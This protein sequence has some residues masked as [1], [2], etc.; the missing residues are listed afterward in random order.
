MRLDIAATSENETWVLT[1]E[2]AQALM[3]GWFAA[4]SEELTDELRGVF[5]KALEKLVGVSYEPELYLGS[6]VVAGRNHCFLCR[7]AV[8]YPGALS[9]YTLVYIYE[10]LQGGASILN[11]SKADLGEK[12]PAE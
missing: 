3:G 9:Y 1:D 4:D 8:I 10:D 12:L 7:S 11:I 2:A 6:Q 5:D